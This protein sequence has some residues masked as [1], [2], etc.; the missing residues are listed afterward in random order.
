MSTRNTLQTF[1]DTVRVP[2][3]ILV[4]VA[5]PVVIYENRA[6]F[7]ELLQAPKATPPAPAAVSTQPTSQEPETAEPLSV[8]IAVNDASQLPESIT[9]GEIVPFSFTIQNTGASSTFQ[10]KVFVEWNSGEQDVI[11]ENVVS[12]PEGQSKSIP[13]SLKFERGSDS[14]E[15]I[16]KVPTAN[17]TLEFALPRKS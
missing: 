10:Y 6:Y 8:T 2:V 3:F 14:S 7:E 4:I 9:A 12:I 11:D 13:E 5:A 15:I 1:L 16:V 17:Q